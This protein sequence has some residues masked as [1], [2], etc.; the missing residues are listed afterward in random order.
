VTHRFALRPATPDDDEDLVALRDAVYPEYAG[1]PP[2]LRLATQLDA[3]RDAPYRHVA[4]EAA[5]NRV[6]GYAAAWPWKARERKYRMD[7]IVHPSCR[8]RGLGTMLL[9]RLL[10][11]LRAAGAT[12][13]QA[14]ARA[15]QVDALVF[16]RRRG[17]ADVQRMDAL[18]LDVTTVEAARQLTLAERGLATGA[19]ITSLSQA[20]A[21][22]PDCLPKLHALQNAVAPDWPDP[23]PTPYEPI[24]FDDFARCLRAVVRDPDGFFLAVRGDRFVG[25]TDIS[26]FGTAVHPD[27]RGRGIATSLKCC[28]I[29]YAKMRRIPRLFA[30]TASPA[31]RA[32]N[33]KLGYLLVRSE[34]RLLKRLGDSAD[35]VSRPVSGS[36]AP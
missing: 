1:D 6:V 34:I 23:D 27:F 2:E 22:D 12:T 29:A 28:L 3:P 14:R 13:L 15:D 36:C 33:E 5:V 10:A 20:S 30:C 7:L 35:S 32:I 26:G 16:L 9:D 11:D 31:M 19:H 4:I 17:F 21:S 18:A 25:Y 8:R 24:P